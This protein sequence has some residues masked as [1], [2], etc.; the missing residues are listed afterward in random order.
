[1]ESSQDTAPPD[2]V[3]PSR[4]A[5]AVGG[6]ALALGELADSYW[7]CIYAWWRRV[8]LDAAPAADATIASLTRWLRVNSPI[9]EDSG[10]GRMREWLPGRLAELAAEGWEPAEEAAIAIEPE[11]AEQNYAGEPEGEPEAIFHRRWALTVLEFTM[12]ALRAEYGARGLETLYGEVAP[13]VGF[14]GADEAHYAAAAER[15]GM[16]GGALK[17]AVFD[18]R[19]HHRDLLR[20]IV[21][22]TVAD[23]ADVSS[24]ITA[25]LCACELP[26]GAEAAPAPLPT[27]IRTFKPDELLARAMNT[28]RM[29]S[30]GTGKWQPPSAAEA[31]RLFPQFELLGMIGRGG[32]G[33]VYRARQVALD[34]EVA[35][36]LLPLEV[37]VDQAFADR[38]VREARAMAK[39]NHPNII[40]VFGFGTTVEGHLY[41]F[42]E[43]VEGANVAQI[44]RG[45]GLEVEQALA[46]TGQVCMALAYAHGKGVIHR[47]IKPANVMVGTDGTAKVADFGL[48]RVDGADPAQYGQTVT[49]TI[50]GTAEYMAPE[51][52][53]G[54]GVDHRAD[55]Y[56]VGAMLYEMLCKE[57]P[58]G[59]IERPSQRV[60][61][62]A[63]LDQIVLKAMHRLPEGRYQS[64]TEM[65]ADLEAARTPLPTTPERHR[66]PMNAGG[67][68]PAYVAP[69]EKSSAGLI[70]A[71]LIVALLVGGAIYFLKENKKSLAQSP[72]AAGHS[73]PAP[74][75][76]GPPI[77][78][79]FKP[80]GLTVAAN[81]ANGEATAMVPKEASP[82]FTEPTA[83]PA[84]PAP[85]TAM[86]KWLD[87]LDKTQQEAFQKQVTKPFDT[88]VEELRKSYLAALDAG[89]AKAAT[90]GKLDAALIWNDERHAFEETGTVELDDDS[91]PAPLRPLH[92]EFR[93]RLAKLETERANRIKPVLANYDAILAKNI[94]LLTQ[95]DRIADALLLKQKR[96]EIA[97]AWL[98]KPANKAT[99]KPFA[100]K[101]RPF[102]NTLG[103]KFVPVPITGGP[104][105]G[106]RVL[107]SVWETRLQD[108]EVFATETGLKWE[109]T[110]EPLL[111]VGELRWD[112]AQAFCTWLTER[113]RKAGKLAAN[114]IYRLPTDHEWSCA[115][116]IGEQEDAA[117]LPR[118]KSGKIPET[119]PWGSAW[120][121]P[122][123][124]GN[125]GGKEMEPALAAG[126]YDWV[127]KVLSDYRD[128]FVERAPVGSLA[129]NSFGLYDLGGNL[130]EWC[131]S[132]YDSAQQNRTLRGGSWDNG[133][134]GD[135]TSAQRWSAD[136]NAHWPTAGFRVVLSAAPTAAP[137]PT[138]QMTEASSQALA[139]LVESFVRNPSDTILASRVAALQ[140]WFGRNADYTATCERMLKWAAGTDKPG[141]AERVAKLA[142]L[143]PVAEPRDREAALALGRRS[144]ELGQGKQE[145]PYFK[146]ARGMAEYRS[147]LYG[148]ADETLASAI[149]TATTARYRPEAITGTA[150]YFRAM[151]LFTQGKLAEARAVFTSTEARMK[152]M[153]TE[154]KP[155]F[156]EDLNDIIIW[157]A[158]KEAKALLQI[159]DAASAVGVW[160]DLLAKL[161][162]AVV[163]KTGQGWRLEKGELFSSE[164]KFAKL[165]LP[166]TYAGTSYR[167]RI[168]L[169]QVAVKDIFL[170][171]LPVGDRAVGFYL[172]GNPGEG[173]DTALACVDGKF[174]RAQLGAVPGKQIKDAALHE[175]EVT[176]RLDGPNAK[177][178]STLDSRPLH[179]WTGPIASLSLNGTW[180]GNAPATTLAL[181]SVANDWVVSE[182][183]AQRLA[184]GVPTPAQTR[185]PEPP[186]PPLVGTRKVKI[187][188]NAP[189]GGR[190]GAA[191]AGQTLAIQYV[192]GLWTD[193]PSVG[194][195]LKDR[196]SPDDGDAQGR[197]CTGVYAV[198]AGETKLL[199]EIPTGTKRKPFRHRFD[200]NY[201]HVILR[202]QDLYVEDNLGEVTYA[203]TLSP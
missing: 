46:I 112:D 199:A 113:E 132:C 182:V 186:E 42:M 155:P 203:V 146:M 159:P 64:A 163:E 17:R 162:P 184:A 177:I 6:D 125:Y 26:G 170:V 36:K 178:S 191:R 40:A 11:W 71:L 183:K 134:R 97:K 110:K 195:D 2:A 85:K 21:A 75:F 133:R 187:K 115:V 118:E 149:Q 122:A 90:T 141:T 181:G 33:A 140:V 108:Y 102:V 68:R 114:E 139:S 175:L 29:T 189:L 130:H 25:L 100:T 67:N 58:Q 9:V 20:S 35:I 180:L 148:E 172:D 50:M 52:K 39:L 142:S 7:Y 14:E 111:P 116:G 147:G 153:P 196:K 194:T 84:T 57:P 158:Y 104:T 55:I 23:P 121:P 80:L 123:G 126:K 95:R 109:K 22:D 160:E 3:L 49:G 86:E 27:A 164:T 60:G 83:S 137:A 176:V 31:A 32:M 59:V 192:E 106:Q 161:T 150:G 166:G 16:T 202:I 34:R 37:S 92:V 174:G 156:A 70:T 173:F 167:V 136:L 127:K 198:V 197:I 129:A 119:Y 120:P 78:A 76:F 152:P 107:F 145:L 79:D 138:P 48:A 61:C 65:A 45:P 72:P 151:M 103:M 87:D 101:D 30:G 13:F 12:Q 77:P 43:Y 96:E 28:V 168:K 88:G 144:V 169:R 44:I 185:V 69:P 154:L 8:G 24:E 200:Q 62:D 74:E 10:A 66:P 51:Q 98:E 15:A 91:T 193:D 18:F 56:S 41:F 38:F 82:D 117:K 143:S 171:T 179:E 128:A 201:S 54:M 47:D 94:I 53:R 190:V 99:V 1:M 105:G 188:A 5:Q 89:Q 131:E 63:R 157:L 4:W 73:A 165:P 19:T 124:A 135:L 93:Q 81:P